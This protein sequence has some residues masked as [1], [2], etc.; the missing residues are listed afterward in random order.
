MDEHLNIHCNAGS[1]RTNIL[2]KLQGYG[3]VL[4]YTNG[5]ANI[6]L[7]FCM[8]KHFHVVYNSHE[9]NYVTVYKKD[10]TPMMYIPR[11]QGFYYCNLWVRYEAILTTINSVDSNKVNYTQHAESSRKLQNNI[12]MTTPGLIQIINKRIL[13]NNPLDC[14]SVNNTVPIFGQSIVNQQDSSY[15]TLHLILP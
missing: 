15:T 11:Q 4:L 9:E 13:I 10:G 3:T 14:Q 8:A 7:M 1:T 5:I 2:G 6:V 12:G